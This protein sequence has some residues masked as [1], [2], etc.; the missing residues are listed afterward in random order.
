MASAF[1]RIIGAMM[2]RALPRRKLV[3]LRLV[4]EA[5]TSQPEMMLSKGTE[6]R[7]RSSISDQ[8][9]MPCGVS[10]S[11]MMSAPTRPVQA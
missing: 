8:R 7:P 2:V 10:L 11:L 3:Q 6:L 1:H 9:S 4:S 5:A